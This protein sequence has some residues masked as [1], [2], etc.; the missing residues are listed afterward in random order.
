MLR[1]YKMT[2][3]GT[4]IEVDSQAY[5]YSSTLRLQA[6]NRV[7]GTVIIMRIIMYM[8][9]HSFCWLWLCGNFC[10]VHQLWLVWLECDVLHVH[11]HKT[12]NKLYNIVH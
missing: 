10:C 8:Q 6:V 7:T 12:A 9:S 5:N 4:Q 1:I 2:G 11:V 3:L